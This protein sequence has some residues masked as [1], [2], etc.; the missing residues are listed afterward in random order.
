[1]MS[2]L[3]GGGDIGSISIPQKAGQYGSSFLSETQLKTAALISEAA[4]EVGASKRDLKIALMT[5]F[6]ESAMG[7]AG[8]YRAVDHDS[9]GPF[10][11]RAAWGPAADRMDIKKSAKMFFHG[12]QAG[13][14]GLFDI[15]GRN[16]MS[17]GAAAQAVQVS[18]HP[19][20]YDKW[21]DEADAIIAAGIG[22]LTRRE[23][24]K[25]LRFGDWTTAGIQKH[26]ESFANS[27]IGAT[28]PMNVQ[29]GEYQHP[30]PGHPTTSG[31]GM[32]WGA[33]HDGVD[34]G[35]PTGTP[36]Y[37][38]KGGTVIFASNYDD[39]G[40]GLHTV[41]DHGGGITSGYAHQ[42]RLG[43]RVGDRVAKGQNIG[44]VGNTG[45]ST[46][47]HLHFQLGRGQ[48][49]GRYSYSTDPRSFGIPGL[50]VG[51]NVMYDNTLANLHKGETVLT[52]PLSEQLRVGIQQ[53]A[54]QGIVGYDDIVELLKRDG[55]RLLATATE[56][57][58]NAYDNST[59]EQQ[60]IELNFVL[61]NANI[62]GVDDLERRFRE[63]GDD[64]IEKIRQEDL[65]KKRRLGGR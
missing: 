36:I 61:Q 10:Q 29:P 4:K 38:T 11:Q 12:G 52:K 40:F 30:V 42:S 41:I 5:A 28:G 57:A 59:T 21:E 51:G 13:Q 23:V 43:A 17:P 14:R 64:I 39:G 47:P 35:A 27:A 2:A 32:R 56:A 6:Q 46:G 18:A 53:L 1:M 65:A 55:H 9:L 24:A 44:F 54:N 20:A 3:S 15:A 45:Q 48:S 7:T 8:M 26:A 62:N 16:A 31:F 19:S 49:G 63:W 50:A 37:A 22:T 33:M 60:K 34:I 58:R 25:N